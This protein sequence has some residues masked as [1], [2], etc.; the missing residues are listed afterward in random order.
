MLVVVCYLL[1][2]SVVVCWLL[3]CVCRMMRGVDRLLLDGCGL[4][5]V[6]CCASVVV[7]GCLLLC[8]V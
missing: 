8:G 5:C 2:V 6:V 4:S 1:C 7:D 3:S